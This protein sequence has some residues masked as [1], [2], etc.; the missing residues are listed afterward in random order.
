MRKILFGIFALILITQ[1]SFARNCDSQAIAKALQ[2]HQR[3]GLVDPYLMSH[4]E[5]V[6]KS[7]ENN[8]LFTV[9]RFIDSNYSTFYTVEL[10]P[11][12]CRVRGIH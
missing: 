9:V 6:G 8:S 2:E 10:N 7:I 3:S 4:Y 1:N 12:N 5:V 11:Q